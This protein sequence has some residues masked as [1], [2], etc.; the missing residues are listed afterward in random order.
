[1]AF[2]F[3]EKKMTREEVIAAIKKAN[4]ELG[5]VPSLNELAGT[6]KLSR[7]AVRRHFGHYTSA[8]DACGL[9]RNGNGYRISLR[10][11]FLDWMRLVRELKKVPSIVEYEALGKHSPGPFVRQFGGWV[12]VP[13]RL[14]RYAQ[15]EHMEAEWKDELDIVAAHLQ[16]APMTIR[17]AASITSPFLRPQL[18]PD[19]PVYGMPMV[20]LD[21]LL[22][23]TNEQGVLFLFG[24]VSRKLGFGVV[25]V[26]SGFPDCRALREVEPGR[27]QMTNIELE[28]LSRN[29]I[30][31]GHDPAKIHLIVCWEH[32]WPECPI[33]VIELKT[34]V[35]RLI[36]EELA[37]AASL[38]LRAPGLRP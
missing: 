36:A 1:V 37:K 5:R 32:N 14:F 24:A 27:C 6:G 8:L 23:P 29:F 26:Q 21:L 4:D 19:E 20:P 16:I 35:K 34:V 7:H 18:R 15:V 9:E 30:G 3:Q 10:S 28:M 33:E 22:E 13:A 2:V 12:Y 38:E 11:L 17:N 31:H 25:H